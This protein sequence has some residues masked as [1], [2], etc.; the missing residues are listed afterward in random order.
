MVPRKFPAT[1][2]CG[3]QWSSGGTKVFLDQ[4]S[5]FNFGWLLPLEASVIRPPF[6]P[7]IEAVTQFFHLS[8]SFL[9]FLPTTQILQRSKR[10]FPHLDGA[11]PPGSQS[12]KFSFLIFLI[13]FSFLG[14]FL[15]SSPYSFLSAIVVLLTV[16]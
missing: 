13:S 4:C 8:F 2:L 11:L 15:L 5:L 1:R 6:Y 7:P 9:F 14:F 3:F 16:I 10:V 12:S